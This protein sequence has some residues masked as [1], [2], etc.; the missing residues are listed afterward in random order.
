MSHRQEL[1]LTPANSA[2]LPSPLVSPESLYGAATLS[3]SQFLKHI[4]L[5][6]LSNML[7]PSQAPHL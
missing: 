2:Q 7:P 4:L 1:R 3:R 5:F 6:P